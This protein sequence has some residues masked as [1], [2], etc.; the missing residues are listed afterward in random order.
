M[1]GSGSVDRGGSGSVNAKSGSVDV[2]DVNVMKLK[3]MCWNVAGWS[4]G[5]RIGGDRVVESHDIRAKVIDFFQP[6]IMCLVET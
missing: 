4:R 2:G 3:M 1:Q 5:D 6:D